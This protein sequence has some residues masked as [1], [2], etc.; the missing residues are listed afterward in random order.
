LTGTWQ[1][2]KE[3]GQNDKQWLTKITPKSKEWTTWIP[4]TTGGEPRYSGRVG[5]S[6]LSP[7]KG[8]M[9]K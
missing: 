4:V 3:K 6:C 5:S 2:P 7:G 9:Q 1:W 8:T